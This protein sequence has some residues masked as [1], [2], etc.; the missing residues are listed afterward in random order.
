MEIFAA[1]RCGS[2]AM[3]PPGFPPSRSRRSG[4]GFAWTYSS[5][6]RQGI[7]GPHAEDD[8]VGRPVQNPLG[9]IGKGGNRGAAL[10]AGPQHHLA[11]AFAFAFR[12]AGDDYSHLALLPV[13]D[14]VRFPRTPV[15]ALGRI[16]CI[17]SSC[18]RDII[19]PGAP[20]RR[21]GW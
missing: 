16:P 10:Q 17:D 15:V 2:L 11:I 5:Q 3:P 4:P 21:T 19:P 13:S 8:Q 20:C 7:G 18:G 1:R 14:G 9:Q 12:H 6:D